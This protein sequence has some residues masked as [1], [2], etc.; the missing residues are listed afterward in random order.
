MFWVYFYIIALIGDP[1]NCAVHFSPQ[2]PSINTISYNK[3]FLMKIFWHYMSKLL[4]KQAPKT[5]AIEIGTKIKLGI[6]LNNQDTFLELL[7]PI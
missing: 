3:K 4:H 5:A 7:F 1:F 6:F 2:T